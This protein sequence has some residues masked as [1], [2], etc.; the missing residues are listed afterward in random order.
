VRPDTSTPKRTAAKA[1][2]WETFS[3]LVCLGLAYAMFGN[4]GGCLIF[5][6]IAFV[7]K[8]V[9]FYF[10]DRAWHMCRWGKIE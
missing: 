6:A 3:N 4:I 1:L 5:T 2:S 7:V 9:L 8:L 10:H